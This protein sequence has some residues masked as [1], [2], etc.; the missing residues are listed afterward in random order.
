VVRALPRLQ[1]L[2]D[3]EVSEE[4]RR[5]AQ[6]QGQDLLHP[7]DEDGQPWVSSYQDH[8]GF[9]NGVKFEV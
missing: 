2:D 7:E 9:S 3:V 6:R 8:N 4:E 5:S 1:K